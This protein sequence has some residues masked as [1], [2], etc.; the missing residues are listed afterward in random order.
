M[1]HSPYL[2]CDR[3]FVRVVGW[4]CNPFRTVCIAGVY[5][6]KAHVFHLHTPF[7]TPTLSYPRWNSSAAHFAL[8]IHLK[9]YDAFV[10][11]RFAMVSTT[12]HPR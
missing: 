9:S 4:Q 5:L 2:V 10:T 3:P 11:L 1:F 6:L 7:V 12:L 8:P